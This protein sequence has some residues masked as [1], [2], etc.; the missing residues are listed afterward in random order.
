V[1]DPDVVLRA[2]PATVQAAEARRAEGAPALASEV[3]GAAAVVRTFSGRA[4]AAQPA[5]IDGAAGAVWAP[6]GKPRVVF[7]F[8]ITAGKIVAI[9]L[10]SDPEL[11]RGLD[12][13]I[14]G[15]V[16]EGED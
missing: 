3:R 13:T 9:D 11:V 10:L 1:L 16:P 12:V 5:L 6:D 2:D 14:L 4:Q 15:D 7:R 8:T